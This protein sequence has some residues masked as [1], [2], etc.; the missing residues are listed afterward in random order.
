MGNSINSIYFNSINSKIGE[1]LLNYKK[2]LNVTGQINEYFINNKK[3]RQL[4]IKDLILWSIIDLI[5]KDFSNKSSQNGP[6]VYRLGHVVFILERGV[7]F[8]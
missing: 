8:P 3:N 5:N 4:I 6:F 2:Y 7:R 1:Y